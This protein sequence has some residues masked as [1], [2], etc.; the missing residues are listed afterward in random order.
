MKSIR[1]RYSVHIV[2]QDQ[3]MVYWY[4]T[5]GCTCEESE[6]IGYGYSAGIRRAIDD[7]RKWIEKSAVCK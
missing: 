5:R 2:P 7:A 1:V 6:M 4:V 3:Q